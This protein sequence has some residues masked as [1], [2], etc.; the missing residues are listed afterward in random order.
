MPAARAALGWNGWAASRQRTTRATPNAAADRITAPT[1]SGS[2]NGT[3]RVQPSGQGLSGSNGRGLG[4]PDLEQRR[5]RADGVERAEQGLGQPE[6]GRPGGRRGRG[7][8]VGAGKPGFDPVGE[9]LQD[10]GHDPRSRDQGPVV[11]AD[12]LPGQQVERELVGRV[13][14]ARHVADVPAIGR[15]RSVLFVAGLGGLAFEA[16]VD[17][18]AAVVGRPR[19]L[20]G[21][22]EDLTERRGVRLA[23]LGHL[24]VA[25]RPFHQDHPPARLQDLAHPEQGFGHRRHRPG[26]DPA[27]L[28]GE[29]RVDLAGE[30]LDP[31]QAEP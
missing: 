17:D 3:N 8:A 5:P 24:V 27:D 10:L 6:P 7:L 4:H 29:L 13:G 22:V 15:G 31:F 14:V 28:A 11:L 9:P 30:D 21:A 26:D 18:E 12:P 19:D 23:G 1:F 16:F 20:V 2:W 25:V